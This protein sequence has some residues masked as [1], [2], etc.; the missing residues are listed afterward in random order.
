MSGKQGWTHTQPSVSVT[1]LSQTFRALIDSGAMVN[2]IG[3]RVVGILKSQEIH[4]QEPE[5]AAVELRMADGSTC[6]S[7]NRYRLNG[8]VGDRPYSWEDFHIPGLT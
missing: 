6:Q 8:L 5:G 3:D 1:L 4:L 7:R 2:L